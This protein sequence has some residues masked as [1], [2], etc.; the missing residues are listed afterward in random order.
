MRSPKSSKGGLVAG[1]EAASKRWKEVKTGGCR[2]KGVDTTG[3]G[4]DQSQGC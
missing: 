1:A 2:E 4:S 3:M